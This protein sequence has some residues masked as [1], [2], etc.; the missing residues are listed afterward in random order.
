MHVGLDELKRIL[1]R[2]VFLAVHGSARE[3]CELG[4]VDWVS[5]ELSEMGR[6]RY[7]RH[8]WTEI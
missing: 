8:L 6:D 3:L 1:T 5:H 7:F 4:L 2:F